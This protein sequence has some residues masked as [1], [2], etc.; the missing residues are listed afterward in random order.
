MLRLIEEQTNELEV[1]K[2]ALTDASEGTRQSYVSVSV[3][4]SILGA[5]KLLKGKNESE[6]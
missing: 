2:Q 3:K 4:K 5:V 6:V 1:Y